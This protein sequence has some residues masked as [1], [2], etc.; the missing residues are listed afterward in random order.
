MSTQDNEPPAQPPV[1][2][3]AVERN[4]SI[5]GQRENSGARP[6]GP[7]I[8]HPAA[9]RWPSQMNFTRTGNG[10]PEAWGISQE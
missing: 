9:S 1:F 3:T 2:L 5:G 10:I 8:G 7:E 4:H 6:S